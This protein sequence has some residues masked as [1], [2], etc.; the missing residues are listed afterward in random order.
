MMVPVTAIRTAAVVGL[1][2]TRTFSKAAS[3]TPLPPE[4]GCSYK[5]RVFVCD[6]ERRLL[7]PVRRDR[8]NGS[9]PFTQ[10][11]VLDRE[12]QPSVCPAIQPPQ[13]TP[14]ARVTQTIPRWTL[15]LID[16]CSVL[17]RLNL[18]GWRSTRIT[19]LVVVRSS[20]SSHSEVCKALGGS[21]GV[22][23]QHN[24]CLEASRV[25]AVA[26]KLVSLQS[27][28]SPDTFT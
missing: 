10:L 1:G 22:G 8:E 14:G 13:R 12:V 18:P 2:K 28:P 3:P 27:D 16:F 26:T 6:D 21:S 24:F 23:P 4:P 9:Q 19:Q 11:P 7:R 15:Y 25:R 17:R 5:V 20:S